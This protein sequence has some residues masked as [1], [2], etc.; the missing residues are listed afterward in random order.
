MRLM[1]VVC[2]PTDKLSRRAT[3]ISP[4]HQTLLRGSTVSLSEGS[5]RVFLLDSGDVIVGEFA[6]LL[7]RLA[8]ELMPLAV[9]DVCVRVYVS[10]S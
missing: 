5:C 10:L 7:P 9:Q 3:I 8:F 6:P 2:V 1:K 4:N